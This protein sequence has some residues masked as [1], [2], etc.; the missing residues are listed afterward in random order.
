MEIAA[1]FE[2]DLLHRQWLRKIKEVL[3][4]N[5][6]TWGLQFERGTSGPCI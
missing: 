4:Q 1:R 3:G 2:V 6:G 5:S